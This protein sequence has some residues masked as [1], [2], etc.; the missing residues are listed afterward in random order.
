MFI[1]PA[2]REIYAQDTERKQD[3]HEARRTEAA[4]RAVY[5]RYGYMLIDLPLASVAERVAFIRR[6]CGAGRSSVP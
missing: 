1:A 5:P 2:W 3:F 6:A 4:M